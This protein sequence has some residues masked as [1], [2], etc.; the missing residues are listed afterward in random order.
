MVKWK[1]GIVILAAS[2]LSI[3]APST[4]FA[5]DMEQ[6]LQNKEANGIVGNEEQKEE[7]DLLS[8]LPLTQQHLEVDLSDY[9]LP[10]LHN[11][12]LVTLFAEEE[13][14]LN[15]KKVAW[16]LNEDGN[17]TISNMSDSIDLLPYDYFYGNHEISCIVGSAK[18]LDSKNT[19]VTVD[20]NIG[21]MNEWLLPTLYMQ[22]EDGTRTEIPVL[23]TNYY[24]GNS[25]LEEQENWCL[26]VGV[27]EDRLENTKEIYLGL[28]FNEFV[29]PNNRFD[30]VQ[31]YLGDEEAVTTGNAEDITEQIWN[32]DMSVDGAGHLSDYSWNNHQKYTLVLKKDG[33]SV[34]SETFE[35][36]V[37]YLI[38]YVSNSKMFTIGTDEKGKEMQKSVV[39]STTSQLNKSKR[40]YDSVITATL[41]QDYSA[42]GQYYQKLHYIDEGNYDN[43]AEMIDMA[44]VGVYN[45]KKS[46][47]AAGAEDIK[48]QLF[49]GDGFLASYGGD[50]VTFSVF[51]GKKVH[52][53]TIKAI[54]SKF[55][56]DVDMD[57][58][59][60]PGSADTYFRVN[61]AAE[62]NYNDYYI[63]PY[64]H[65]TYYYNGFQTVFVINDEIDFSTI[66]PNFYAGQEV[67]MYAG[68]ISE[69]Q[70][71][72]VSAH[73]FTESPVHYTASAGDKSNVKEYWVTF[74]QKDTTGAK[75]Y[76]NGVNGEQGA[77]RELF[78]DSFYGKHHDIIIANIGSEP[79]TGLKVELTD[80]KNV[81]LDSYWK[82]GGKKNDTLAAFDTAV[83]SYDTHGELPN[84]AK[85]RLLPNGDGDVSGTLTISAD[86]QEPVIIT[87]TGKAGDPT[88]V[89]KEIPKAVKYVPYGTMIQTTNMYDWNKISF[90][91]I[92]GKLPIGVELKQN[93]EI[94][95]VPKE[96]GSFTFTV[97]MESSSHYFNSVTATY[98]LEVLENTS[99]NVDA[100]TD[101]G[102]TIMKRVP[103]MTGYS[104]EIFEIEG[105]LAE[106]IDLWLDGEKMEKDL[107]Y[108]AE[109]GS[110][111]ITIYD[112]T[113]EEAGTG[114]HTIAAEFRVNG[115]IDQ[116]LKKAAQNYTSS[117]ASTSQ[118]KTNKPN[119]TGNSSVSGKKGFAKDL[120][121]IQVGD[122]VEY[123]GKVHYYSSD[124]KTSITCKEGEAKVTLIYPSGD[125]P[126]HLISLG[127]GGT[128]YGWV[129]GNYIIIKDSK[130]QEKG[131]NDITVGANVRVKEGASN[132]KGIKLASFVFKNVY[133]VLY[134]DGERVVI[135]QDN[136]ITAAVNI[137]D[138]II[139]E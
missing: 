21:D 27:S 114:N 117:K 89:T 130:N 19:Y 20:V 67:V 115:D 124:S 33:V 106:F 12:S 111:K 71:S 26:R 68:Q 139:S 25:S 73:N 42:N 54:D 31:I 98:T 2:I 29:D 91:L 8:L 60:R 23:T 119:N 66:R 6:K 50:G 63:L 131:T 85:I 5:A 96:T 126:Y 61:G 123:N 134:V 93:G 86:N 104:N 127:K 118:G 76:V 81:K 52:H 90:R 39:Y 97:R 14:L 15:S 78:L 46:A 34:G 120:D 69:I 75:L 74:I 38:S 40:G 138:L 79:L 133:T 92:S 108:T 125:H 113:F 32:V 1:R 77:R 72:G 49:S 17:Y 11:L 4:I 128:V 48:E 84:L 55:H 64:K 135:G 13:K 35:I 24:K 112:K 95:G 7:I 88:I 99:E 94:Y 101:E 41:Y 9:T 103:N 83:S 65:D 137:H 107:N 109:E 51:V 16:C 132:Y 105:V 121:G 3:Q 102:Y 87:L 80:A 22:D 58:P 82:V 10:E 100:S 110:T 30:T 56:A 116:E 36:N 136:I 62:L 47:I 37:N 70:E 53:V 129:D 18:Q 28:K 44:V 122:I 43:K 45:T 59:S 57:I